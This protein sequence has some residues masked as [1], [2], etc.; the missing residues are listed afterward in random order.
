MDTSSHNMHTLF[1]QL[2]LPNR[3]EDI[4][5]FIERHHGLEPDI[6]LNQ[7]LFWNSTQDAFLREAISEDS[8]WCEV[9]DMLDSRLR[10]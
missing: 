9:V 7:A 8:D 5:A 2:G 3:A 6:P 10:K 4:D 1:L